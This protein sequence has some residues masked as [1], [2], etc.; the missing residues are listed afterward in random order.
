MRIA[1][2]AML[3]AVL[4]AATGAGSATPAP[5]PTSTPYLP[6]IYHTISRPLCSALVTKI[7]PALGMMIQNDAAIAKSPGYFQE[8]IQRAGEDNEVGQNIAVLHLENL[9]QPL[10]QNALAIQKLLEDPSV[11]PAVA[12]N[13]D[14]ARLIQ[15]KTQMLKALADQQASIDIINGFVDTQQL[16]GMQHEGFGYLSSINTGPNGQADPAL[17][18]LVGPTPDPTKPEMFDNLALNAGL[19]P[20]SYEIDPTRIPGLALGYNPIRRLKDGVV[21]TQDQSKKHEAPLADTIITTTKY[22]DS[23]PAT[24]SPNP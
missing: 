16:S 21:W 11:F 18:Q 5:A 23:Q 15:I 9:V 7:K 8:Y 19:T 22:C 24:P 3:L 13:P 2:L 20:N 14:D 6:E 1:P 17:Q 12:Q 4:F 10:V